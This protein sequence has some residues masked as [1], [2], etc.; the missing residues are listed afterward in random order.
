MP[1]K[2]LNS[3][4][5][6]L[7]PVDLLESPKTRLKASAPVQP[8]MTMESSFDSMVRIAS[9]PEISRRLWRGLPSLNWVAPGI[10]ASRTA[11]KLV[12]VE[13]S[14]VPILVRRSL[15]QGNVIY[16]GSD[17]FWRWRDRARWQYFH[18]FWG[19]LLLW[20]AL[21]RTGSSNPF[22]KLMTSRPE[23]H[24]NET[25]EVSVRITGS[26]GMPLNK[27]RGTLDVY[28]QTTEKAVK[29][30]QLQ[31]VEKSD[32][33]Y[34]AM[35]K[36]LPFGKY[37]AS[38]H[39]PALEG[40]DEGAE[41]RFEVRNLPGTEY[42]HLTLNPSAL[43][44]LATHYLPLEKADGV[45]DLIPELRVPRSFRYEWSI[46]NTFPALAIIACLL[47]LEWYLRKRQRLS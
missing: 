11:D 22:V 30:V 13:S 42:T 36:G 39:I 37:R 41:L 34:V 16:L 3:P 19:Q 9:T 32:G 26:G 10:V 31:Y 28:D 15:G 1:K 43:K 14:D 46:W 21:D 17:S 33:K 18:R 35:L 25:I 2:Y 47:G 20:A 44:S 40:K 45:P 6:D 7:L 29:I 38:T 24:P 27:T 8:T 4:L 5:S 23:Y 12:G